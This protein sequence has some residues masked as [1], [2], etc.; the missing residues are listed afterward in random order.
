MPYKDPQ[1]AKEYRNRPEVRASRAEANDRWRNAHP[2]KAAQIDRDKA[3]RYRKNHP[4]KVRK[5]ISAWLEK[6]P[7]WVRDRGRRRILEKRGI[8]EENLADLLTF[9]NNRCAICKSTSACGKN[10]R[11]INWPIDH[12]HTTGD[13]RGLLC[14]PCNTYLGYL[15]TR[16]LVENVPAFSAYVNNPPA[17]SVLKKDPILRLVKK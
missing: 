6:N 9:Q 17:R 1:K 2:E 14:N 5:S 11:Y 8:T 4:E 13:V 3:K 10:G 12:D 15:E 16:K 7:D